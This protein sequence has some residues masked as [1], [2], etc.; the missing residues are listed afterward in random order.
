MTKDE[1]PTGRPDMIIFEHDHA[2]KVKSMGICT[3]DKHAILLNKPK[4]WTNFFLSLP[5]PKTERC[6]RIPGVVL[7]VPAITPRNP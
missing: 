2:R 4:A 5:D 3:T 6:T 7:R 1:R